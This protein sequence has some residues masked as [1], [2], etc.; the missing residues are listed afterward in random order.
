MMVWGISELNPADI[1]AFHRRT[2]VR[3][4]LAS[5]ANARIRQAFAV[6]H[7]PTVALVDPDGRLGER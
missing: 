5:D 3:F 7:C 6:E 4:P 1:R 2:G